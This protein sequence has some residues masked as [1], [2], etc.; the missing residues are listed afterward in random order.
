MLHH[1]VAVPIAQ[2]EVINELT[3]TPPSTL[4]VATIII[5]AANNIYQQRNFG[6]L[7]KA[8]DVREANIKAL[9]DKLDLANTIQKAQTESI[10]NIRDDT[11]VA[12]NKL[13]AAIAELIAAVREHVDLVRAQTARMEGKE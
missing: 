3:H 9:L 6:R 11:V 1:I 2:I 12:L 7:Q 5:L 10:N 13:V 8:F 4:L